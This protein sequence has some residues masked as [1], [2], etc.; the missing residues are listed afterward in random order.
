MKI[1]DIFVEEMLKLHKITKEEAY[2]IAYNTCPA[3]ID[4]DEELDEAEAAKMKRLLGPAVEQLKSE[5]TVH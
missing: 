5:N 4:P 3:E 1:I 2:R